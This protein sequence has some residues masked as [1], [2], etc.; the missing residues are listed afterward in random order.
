VGIYIEISSDLLLEG[1]GWG[2]VS[3]HIEI[4]CWFDFLLLF[5]W[6]QHNNRKRKLSVQI[7]TKG[8]CMK[9]ISSLISLILK[10][11]VDLIFFFFLSGINT[12]T[13]YSFAILRDTVVLEFDTNHHL[14]VDAILM[15]W[16]CKVVRYKWYSF[17]ILRDTVVLEFWFESSS[18]R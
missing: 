11:L 9:W 10:L 7:M 12:I 14:Y 18:L 3:T 8:V 17:A 2:R 16:T 4:T 13:W 1:K 6:Y 15:A 5:E